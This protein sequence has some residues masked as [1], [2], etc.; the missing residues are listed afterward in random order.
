MYT[1]CQN[2]RCLV[3]H[4][5]L[6]TPE[7]PLPDGRAR[8][9]HSLDLLVQRRA[10]LAGLLLDLLPDLLAL[11]LNGI[12]QGRRHDALDDL[13]KPAKLQRRCRIDGTRAAL[14]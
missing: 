11:V 1:V 5:L 6:A 7:D 4:G 10:R 3:G 12:G 13:W 8:L 14:S 2:S 9:V